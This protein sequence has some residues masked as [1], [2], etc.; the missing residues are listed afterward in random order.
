M[1]AKIPAG[2]IQGPG[3]STAKTI[4][5]AADQSWKG[6]EGVSQPPA[7]TAAEALARD[8]RKTPIN[9]KL[10]PQRRKGVPRLERLRAAAKKGG[11]RTA[12]L[13]GKEFCEGRSQRG[14]QS[15]LVRYGREYYRAI[16]RLR[17]RYE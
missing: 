7:N 9:P 1:S 3:P 13:Y 12:E 14:G 4:Q 8:P 15:C 10:G 2:P 17:G 11:K 16:R 5:G 6:I